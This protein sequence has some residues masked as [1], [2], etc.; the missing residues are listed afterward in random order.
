MI[1]KKIF[2]SDEQCS[3]LKIIKNVR[4]YRDI[5]SRQRNIDK[6]YSNAKD[7]YEPKYPLLINK[8]EGV[9]LKHCNDLKAFIEY[10]NTIDDIYE[11]IEEYN[12]NKERKILI[13]FD[14]MIADMLNNK[15]LNPIVTE[16]FI[17]VRKVNISLDFITQS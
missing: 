1:W 4:K 8:R 16:L 7:P 14:D 15:K 11:N 10:S 2:Q 9:G 3:F 17:R 12:L 13:V 5:V 6:I